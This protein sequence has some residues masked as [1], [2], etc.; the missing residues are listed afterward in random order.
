MKTSSCC[1]W[2][3]A[4][5]FL[6]PSIDRTFCDALNETEIQEIIG[7]AEALKDQIPKEELS[8]LGNVWFPNRG[9]AG[10]LDTCGISINATPEVCDQLIAQTGNL[11]CQCYNFCDSRL[12]GCHDRGSDLF[13]D[14]STESQSCPIEQLVTGC[15]M[16]Y[17]LPTL[18]RAAPCPP[19]YI[20]SRTGQTSC[21]DLRVIYQSF[22]LGDV[23]AGAYCP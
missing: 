15:Y 18:W 11:S 17:T 10:D 20:C 1:S 16:N 6:L 19:G 23:H 5:W 12:I 13:W 2:V 21:D 3:V 22:G 4:T 7:Q 8:T 14:N 9:A